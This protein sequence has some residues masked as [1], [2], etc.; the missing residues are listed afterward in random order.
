MRL[1]PYIIEKLEKQY[2]DFILPDDQP[3]LS[4]VS[5]AK[6]LF[7]F[8]ESQRE[9]INEDDTILFDFM[10]RIDEVFEGKQLFNENGTLYWRTWLSNKVELRSDVV[11]PMFEDNPIYKEKNLDQKHLFSSKT[12]RDLSIILKN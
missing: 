3:S 4:N 1:F 5:I 9:Y 2:L 10:D 8:A 7:S 6:R 12:R 11:S